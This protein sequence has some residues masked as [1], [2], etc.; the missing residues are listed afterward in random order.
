MRG[1]IA[2]VGGNEWKPPAAP[3]DSWLLERSGANI[4]TIVPTA[5]RQ[6][7]EM[8][9]ETAAKYFSEMG[10]DVD[11]LMV[12]NREDADDESQAK[13]VSN[14]KFIYIAGGDP[15]FLAQSLRD[16]KVW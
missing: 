13:T 16:T 4:V 9:V 2:L 1:P 5:S 7:P 15:G 11:G 6:H 8:A 3:L 12:L 14:S 10:A